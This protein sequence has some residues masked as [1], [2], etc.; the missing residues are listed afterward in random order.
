MPKQ[1][2]NGTL[3]YVPLEKRGGG[4]YIFLCKGGRCDSLYIML[5]KETS[6]QYLIKSAKVGGGKRSLPTSWGKKG[7]SCLDWVRMTQG[8]L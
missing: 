5:S 6:C 3:T 1:I 7:E 8:S 2:V 4:E